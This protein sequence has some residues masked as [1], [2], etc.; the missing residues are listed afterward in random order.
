MTIPRVQGRLQLLFKIIS[1]IK[2]VT[3]RIGSHCTAP[4]LSAGFQMTEATIYP[5]RYFLSFGGR[6][7]TFFTYNSFNTSRV[8]ATNYSNQN[9][10][11][12]PQRLRFSFPK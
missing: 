3:F 4:M 8:T 2:L 9:P 11:G 1:N 12:L 10:K 7:E 6:G 5:L